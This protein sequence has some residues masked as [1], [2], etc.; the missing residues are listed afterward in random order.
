MIPGYGLLIITSET[1]GQGPEAGVVGRWLCDDVGEF[2][3]HR[4]LCC[5]PAVQ[6]GFM[7]RHVSSVAP[8][9]SAGAPGSL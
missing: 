1:G 6:S 5:L 4:M 8:R 2:S 7:E 9:E 3:S